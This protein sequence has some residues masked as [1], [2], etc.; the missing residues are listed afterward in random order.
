MIRRMLFP[1]ISILLRRSIPGSLHTSPRPDAPPFGWRGVFLVGTQEMVIKDRQR[2]L[3]LTVWYP[4]SSADDHEQIVT[5]TDGPVKFLGQALRNAPPNLDAA[6]YPLVI[7]SHG[8]GGTRLQSLYFT[9]HLA[10]H[11]FVVMAVDHKGNTAFDGILVPDKYEENRVRNYIYRPKDVLRQLSFAEELTAP[12]GKLAG[13]IDVE[14]V[15]VTGHS[16]GGYT[17]LA[18]GGAR[19]NFDALN[20][21]CSDPNNLKLDAQTRGKVAY[22]RHHIEVFK[23]MYELDSLPKGLWP[24]TSDPRFKAVLAMAPWNAPIFGA[25]GLA[26]VKI[27]AMILVGS[28]DRITVPQ[29]DAYV[30]YELLGSPRKVLV[31]FEHG[32]H[33]I[34]VDECSELLHQFDLFEVCSDSVWDMTRVHDLI[35]HLGTAFLRAVLYDDDEAARALAPEQVDFRGV[36]YKAVGF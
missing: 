15:A 36:Q 34:F 27:P 9:E 7:F 25:E 4:A 26:Q 1:V 19:L 29:R 17:A 24:P 33:F 11:G 10:S 13:L 20:A 14:R 23:E 35:N 8:S 32:G 2:P 6:P 5:Y 16:F 28:A 30:F 18:V 31:T 21:W 22:V 12:Q 3:K